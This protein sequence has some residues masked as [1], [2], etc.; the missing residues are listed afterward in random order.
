MKAYSKHWS[1]VAISLALLAPSLRAE[2]LYVVNAP[3]LPNSGNSISAYRIAENGALTSVTGS[4]FPAGSYPIS[5][6]VD[7]VA[8]FVYVAN[9]LDNNVSAYR[10]RENGALTVAGSPFPAGGEP[11]SVAFSPGKR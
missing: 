4:P 5:V 6:A 1:L 10:I 2:F 7:S 3:D 11:D 9:A 8:G